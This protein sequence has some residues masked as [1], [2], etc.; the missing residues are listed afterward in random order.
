MKKTVWLLFLA[1]LFSAG[2]GGYKIIRNETQRPITPQERV[3]VANNWLNGLDEVYSRTGYK[4]VGDQLADIEKHGVVAVPTYKAMVPSRKIAEGDLAIVPLFKADENI[5]PWGKHFSSPN[6]AS[7]S[8]PD[9]TIILKGDDPITLVFEGIIFSHEL[10]H[11]SVDPDG[12]LMDTAINYCRGEVTAHTFSNKLTLKIG[13]DAYQKILDKRA[14]EWAVYFNNPKAKLSSAANYLNDMEKIFGRSLSEAEDKI[15][16]PNFEIAA[17][18]LMVDK[19]YTAGD[20]EEQK[21]SLMCEMYKNN[22]N[23]LPGE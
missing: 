6:M 11:R 1:I 4:E 10:M 2:I 14:Q 7:Y 8:G 9:K 22:G 21:A 19:Y 3:A 13:G 5:F 20:K 18:Y 15:R 17:I 16:V 12:L 23:T